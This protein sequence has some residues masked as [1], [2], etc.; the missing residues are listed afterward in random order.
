MRVLL[1]GSTQWTDADDIRLILAFHPEIHQLCK[2]RGS[3]H[4]LELAVR[5]GV[6]VRASDGTIAES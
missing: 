3:R 6:P 2:A 5:S 1:P 4:M